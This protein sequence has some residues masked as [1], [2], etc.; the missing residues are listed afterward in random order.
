MEDVPFA[1]EADVDEVPFADEADVADVNIGDRLLELA[2][3][4]VFSDKALALEKF[5]L[6]NLARGLQKANTVKSI[7]AADSVTRAIESLVANPTKEN[8]ID[9]FSPSNVNQLKVMI[10]AGFSEAKEASLL[11]RLAPKKADDWYSF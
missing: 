10:N 4:P 3:L 5:V 11:Y 9:F 8:I 2:S 7:G 6:T 1:D